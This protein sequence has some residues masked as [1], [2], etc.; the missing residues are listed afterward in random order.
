MRKTRKAM[1]LIYFI[2][3]FLLWACEDKENEDP[4]VRITTPKDEAVLNKGEIVPIKAMA[5]DEDGSI[6]SISIYIGGEEVGSSEESTF[7]YY[8]NTAEYEP[9]EYVLGAAATDNEAAVDVVNIDVLLGAPGGLNPELD[10]DTLTDIDGNVYASIEIGNQVWMAE[11][12]KVTHYA[13]GAPIA[14]V[15]DEAAWN[16]LAPEDQAYCWYNNQIEYRDTSGALYTWAA[17]MYGGLSSDTVGVQG[18]CPDGWHLPADKEWKILEMTLGMSQ[19]D[20][21]SYDWRGSDE[22]GQLK[23]L[24]FSNWAIPNEGAS[25]SSGFTAIPGGFRSFKGL[26]YSID[27]YASFWAATADDE[28]NTAWYRTLN[29]QREEIYRQ[30]NNMQIGLSVRCVKN[31]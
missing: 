5:D 19:A 31:Q 25:N 30:H 24:G 26:F 11:N 7:I 28:N 10:Y 6:A 3:F 20:A 9:A 15:S 17:A 2:P 21:D 16:D 22:G 13:D 27:E 4:S 14:E 23:E 29:Y 8:W 18:V 1:K 12:L